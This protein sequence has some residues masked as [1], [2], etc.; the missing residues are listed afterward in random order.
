MAIAGSDRAVQSNH[1]NLTGE[2]KS[3]SSRC[4][5]GTRLH[6]SS[7]F[8]SD[9]VGRLSD[10]VISR[11]NRL[12]RE[13]WNTDA[14][15]PYLSICILASYSPLHAPPSRPAFRQRTASSIGECALCHGKALHRR[16][17][18]DPFQNIR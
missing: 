14:M 3:K 15:I 10:C 7:V 11:C 12:Q 1:N 16:D 6:E 17:C 18:L 2:S 4:R 9:Q 5:A 8:L 13:R